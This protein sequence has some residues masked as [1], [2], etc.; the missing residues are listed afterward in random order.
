MLS[1]FPKSLEPALWCDAASRIMARKIFSPLFGSR[2]EAGFCSAC[3]QSLYC[4]GP[5]FPFQVD[6]S[7][8]LYRGDCDV[9]LQ[10]NEDW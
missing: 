3:L 5:S 9:H 6:A 4:I 10:T 1:S 2:S 7:T 8:M